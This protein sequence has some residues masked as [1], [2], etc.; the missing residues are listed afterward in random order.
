M[1][2]PKNQ[3][4]PKL[5]TLLEVFRSKEM[6]RSQSMLPSE[7]SRLSLFF[8]T[9]LRLR[10]TNLRKETSPRMVTSDLVSMNILILESSM[11]PTQ[12]FSVE[13]EREL[14]EESTLRENSESIKESPPMMP[15]N[16]SPKRWPE[17]S[18]DETS[19]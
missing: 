11:I 6:R 1:G 15:S 18:S 13:P 5:D 3:L 12:V 19:Y 2:P 17:L 9:P 4:N 16:G 8:K 14:L 10:N 7:E